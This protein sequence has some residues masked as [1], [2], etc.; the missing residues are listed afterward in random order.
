MSQY[1]P[2]GG[3]YPGQQPDRWA[4]RQSSE[5]F[6][7]PSDPW[8]GNDPWGD[9]P[10]TGPEQPW[11]SGPEQPWHG[12]N[13]PNWQAGQPPAA[14]PGWQGYGQHTS[15]GDQ[16]W[17]SATQPAHGWAGAA[18]PTWQQPGA[19][20]HSAATGQHHHPPSA[21]AWEPTAE[22]GRPGK[23]VGGVS[24]ALL[25]VVIGLT[26]L[27]CG[28]G[29]AGIYLVTRSEAQNAG[30]GLAVPTTDPQLDSSVAPSAGTDPTPEPTRSDDPAPSPTPTSDAR[31]VSV[32][33]CVR[34][35][36]EDDDATPVLTITGCDAGA[37][38]VLARFDE[39]TDGENDAKTK[40]ADVTGYTNWYFFNSQLDAL[41][42]V[43][44]LKQR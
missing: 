19:G 36:A 7:E 26:V 16:N 40:C 42:F 33:Q 12:E 22:P 8:G 18:D 14:Q 13:D 4:D 35:E 5:P 44:C 32:G 10:P 28:G 25:A 24:R 27:L 31:F 1:G 9:T 3:P 37:Y 43:L 29:A 39:V 2:P 34:N 30:E 41:D 15:A 21:P 20:Q 6:R 17:H 11:R 38:E 23:K